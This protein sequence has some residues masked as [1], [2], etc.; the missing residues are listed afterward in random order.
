M[1]LTIRGVYMRRSVAKLTAEFEMRIGGSPNPRNPKLK[2]CGRKAPSCGCGRRNTCLFCDFCKALTRRVENRFVARARLAAAATKSRRK[3]IIDSLREEEACMCAAD[4][5]PGYFDIETQICTPS[6]EELEKELAADERNLLGDSD[7]ISMFTTVYLYD[8]FS[9]DVNLD[10]YREGGVK[11]LFQLTRNAKTIGC[12]FISTD[13][14][15]PTDPIP[16]DAGYPSPPLPSCPFPPA[17]SPCITLGD[18]GRGG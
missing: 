8:G 2:S 18:W 1:N 13:V 7:T 4:T 15:L 9:V 12:F 10:D 16:S 14:Q 5:E 17:L 3:A 11:R 6:R